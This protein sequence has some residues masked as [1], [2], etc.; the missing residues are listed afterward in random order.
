MYLLLFLNKAGKSSFI[1]EERM[2][3]LKEKQLAGTTTTITKESGTT[4]KEN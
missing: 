4:R 1:D 3:Q 2:P